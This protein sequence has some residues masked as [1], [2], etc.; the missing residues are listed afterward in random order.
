MEVVF[1]S[2]VFL[3]FFLP[4]LFL[5]YFCVPRKFRGVR[6]GVLLLFS[7]FF[8]RCGGADYFPLL[9]VSIGVNYAGGLLAASERVWVRRLG[10]WG[11]VAIG[12]G[13]LGWFKYAGFAAENLRLLGLDV[14]V[15]EI[16]R[17]ST[18]LNSSHM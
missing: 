12:L 9:L 13:L 4:L 1:S 14:P 6:N 3:L 5:C 16:D 15:P 10:L 7:L 11:A 8:Y 2:L 18:R 17:K